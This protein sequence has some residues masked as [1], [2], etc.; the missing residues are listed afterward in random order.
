MD[1]IDWLIICFLI[2]VIADLLLLYI[3]E[4]MQLVLLLSLLDE[5]AESE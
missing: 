4:I 3:R 5:E 2:C 1:G